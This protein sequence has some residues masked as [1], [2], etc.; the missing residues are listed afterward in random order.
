VASAAGGNPELVEDGVSGI[1]VPPQDPA[2]LASAVERLLG[3][4]VLASRLGRAA[5][6]RVVAGFSTDVRLD[7][8]EALYGD[9]VAKAATIDR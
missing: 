9:L 5:R 3:D 2:A 6:A 4:P 7:R 8:I 1:L